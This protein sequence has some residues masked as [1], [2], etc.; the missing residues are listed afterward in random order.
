[1]QYVY[2]NWCLDDGLGEFC[3]G[4][5]AGGK[6][7][8][9]EGGNHID[10]LKLMAVRLS[11]LFFAKMERAISPFASRLITKLSFLTYWKLKVH[12]IGSCLITTSHFG[13][14][15]FKNQ[16]PFSRVTQRVRRMRVHPI[17]NRVLFLESVQFFF[18][19]FSNCLN[20][21]NIWT[22]EWSLYP[23]RCGIC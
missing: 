23:L 4:I 20:A 3:N 7:T 17:R 5:S 9:E 12:S 14:N 8:L 6:H 10:I 2:S 1:M 22:L 13:N 19:P 21:L 15:C 16:P 11:I 18:C